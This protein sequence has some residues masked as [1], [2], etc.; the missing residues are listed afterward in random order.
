MPGDRQVD[1][2]LCSVVWEVVASTLSA[3]PTDAPLCAWAERHEGGGLNS[4]TILMF[5]REARD[6]PGPHKTKKEGKGSGC[7]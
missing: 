4:E 6:K 2:T 3:E 7:N 5:C 1:D